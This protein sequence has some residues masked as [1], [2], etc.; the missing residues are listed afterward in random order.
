MLV[1]ISRIRESERPL[2]V[3]AAFDERSLKLGADG[4]VRLRQP[5]RVRLSVSVSGDRVRVSGELD[6]ELA[7][8]CSRCVKP[9]ERSLKKSFDLEYQPDPKVAR[10]G[11]ELELDYGDLEVGFYRDD[12]LD[13]CPVI[14]E[15]ILLDLPMKPLCRP[16]CQ[17][18]CDQC[19]ADLNQG[20]CSCVRVSLDPRL[21]ALLDLKKR[22]K[23]S[24]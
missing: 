20:K 5:V 3:D 21:S 22:M 18:L 1:D 9:F 17:G 16:E 11:E 4:V 23:E 13:L 24:N 6:A 15:Q 12:E 8:V 19:G 10:D 2:L 14:G 7:V